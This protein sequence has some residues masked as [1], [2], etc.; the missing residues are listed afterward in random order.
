MALP[1]GGKWRIDSHV[2]V[3]GTS[4]TV[5]YTPVHSTFP[6]DPLWQ[7]SAQPRYTPGYMARRDSWDTT[8]GTFTCSLLNTPGSGYTYNLGPTLTTMVWTETDGT[9]HTLRE[10]ATTGAPEDPQ[11]TA[12]CQT[13]PTTGGFNRGT[14]FEADDGTAMTFIADSAV[15]DA[16]TPNQKGQDTLNVVTGWLILKDG[17][18]YQTDS[19]GRVIKIRDRTGNQTSLQYVSPGL[20]VTDSMGRQTTVSYSSGAGSP[21]VISYTGAGRPGAFDQRSLR[22]AYESGFADA[23]SAAFPDD[24]LRR[25]IHSGIRGLKDYS[26]RQQPVRFLVQQ[27]R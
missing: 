16:I 18:R 9:E 10:V 23:G 15:Y 2:S 25:D 17:T 7:V 8:G 13:N 12:T 11:A 1:I 6:V 27:L 20:V 21:D 4:E 5:T 3:N 24:F 14:V 19:T 22:F 26:G